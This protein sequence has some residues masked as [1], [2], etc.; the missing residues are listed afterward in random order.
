M[1]A[2]GLPHSYMAFAPL[3]VSMMLDFKCVINPYHVF[4]HD[5]H[6]S[7]DALGEEA[8]ARLRRS[9]AVMADLMRRLAGRDYR[10]AWGV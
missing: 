4:V 3:A 8:S 2:A 6:W 9:A 10:S 5:G 7:G 1:T